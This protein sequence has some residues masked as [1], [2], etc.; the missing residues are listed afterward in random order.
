V[1][2][3][4]VEKE[5]LRFHPIGDSVCWCALDMDLGVI[6]AARTTLPRVIYIEVTYNNS[7]KGRTE[8]GE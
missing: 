1:A 6:H 4:V 7:R 2:W 5:A 3:V 8:V